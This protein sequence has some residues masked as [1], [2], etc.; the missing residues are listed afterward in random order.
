MLVS[1]GSSESE[2]EPEPAKPAPSKKRKEAGPKKI[3]LDLPDPL[4]STLPEEERPQKKLKLTG[5]TGKSGL[6]GL[7]PAPKKKA[8]KSQ[9]ANT[10][11]ATPVSS[12]T[13][14]L[15]ETTVQPELDEKRTSL[16]PQRVQKAGKAVPSLVEK[17]PLD[18]FSISTSSV[19][20]SNAK[21][22]TT[23]N[24]TAS[25][26]PTIQDKP[27]LNYYAS[28]PPA[29]P[30]NPYPGFRCLPSGQWE[31]NQPEE[32]AEW[33]AQNGY[34]AQSSLDTT[35]FN[36]ET[37]KGFEA[38]KFGQLQEGSFNQPTEKPKIPAKMSYVPEEEDE[39]AA[40]KKRQQMAKFQGRAR[41]KNQLSSLLT[42][43]YSKRNELEERIALA[44]ANR[45]AGGARYGQVPLL[46]EVSGFILIEMYT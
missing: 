28:L 40:E 31:P 16:I 37:P 15:P 41:G 3:L 21:T 44:K 27:K 2:T 25:S 4:H 33:A 46:L 38:S 1:Y 13:T 6:A 10:D 42:E 23:T 17:Q 14:L 5:S 39:E 26:A 36:G 30:D 24:T 18:F 32:W 8:A 12:T 43:A 45:K 20:S 35:T 22:L 34:S 29:T 11:T 7:L 9:P 19:P